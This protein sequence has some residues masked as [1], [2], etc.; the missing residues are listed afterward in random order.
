MWGRNYVIAM[1]FFFLS[2]FYILSIHTTIVSSDIGFV[3]L[4]ALHAREQI[5][6]NKS[7][8]EDFESVIE[9]HDSTHFLRSPEYRKIAYPP[10]AILLMAIPGL[11]IPYEGVYAGP[12]M[13]TQALWSVLFRFL[14]FIFEAL[15]FI[16]L[17]W[18]CAKGTCGLG[19]ENIWFY[20]LLST[21]HFD[22]LYDRLDVVSA[23]LV[24]IM[25]IF[26]TNYRH[27]SL[28]RLLVVFG[29]WS[30]SVTYKFI[31]IFSGP[32]LVIFAFFSE[33][34]SSS[35]NWLA[36]GLRVFLLSV[37]CL[38]LPFL[39]FYFFW[40][41]PTFDW[42]QF[43]ALRPI[44]LESFWGNIAVVSHFISKTSDLRIESSYGSLNVVGEFGLI[45]PFLASVFQ[46]LGSA[47]VS[48][49]F[50]FLMFFMRGRIRGESGFLVLMSGLS[51][52]LLASILLGKV[53]SVQFIFNVFP[54]LALIPLNRISIGSRNQ[55]ICLSLIVSFLSFLIFPMFFQKYVFLSIGRHF[56]SEVLD[57]STT[58]VG[59]WLIFSRNLAM[60]FLIAVLMRLGWNKVFYDL[61]Q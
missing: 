21:T 58:W 43:N 37:L 61:K 10:M 49:Y 53:F 55:L 31:P 20:L 44:H 9:Q 48:A 59:A 57:F 11:F 22:L 4:Y 42:I 23:S 15:F 28:L 16:L 32:L 41:S 39:V 2:R 35:K 33:F 17:L 36:H 18:I 30:S 51:A 54:L 12:T 3:S 52:C 5:Q 19:I 1:L 29:L 13:A 46:L 38:V 45:T 14:L 7:P 40:G 8:Y 27:Y 50:G 6:Q 60:L 26:F 47:L 34:S 25:G 24:G 56:R